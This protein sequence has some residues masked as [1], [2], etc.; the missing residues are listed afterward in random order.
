MDKNI[1]IEDLITEFE[2][3]ISEQY[4]ITNEEYCEFHN[5]IEKQIS[6][7][8]NNYEFEIDEFGNEFIDDYYDFYADVVSRIELPT[9]L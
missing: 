3:Y 9:I 2:N 1:L 7:I 4:N 5:S 6:E 8:I